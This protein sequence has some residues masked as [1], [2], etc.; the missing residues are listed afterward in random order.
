MRFPSPLLLGGKPQG[1][2]PCRFSPKPPLL[3]PRKFLFLCGDN[4]RENTVVSQLGICSLNGK[5]FLNVRTTFAKCEHFSQVCDSVNYPFV[6]LLA[7][8][9]V[10]QASRVKIRPKAE[11]L[12]LRLGKLFVKQS[13]Q[14]LVRYLCNSEIYG[15]LNMKDNNCNK[16]AKDCHKWTNFRSSGSVSDYMSLSNCRRENGCEHD[17]RMTS[18]PIYGTNT[19]GTVTE[20]SAF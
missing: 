17:Y 3:T 16:S 7:E 20:P 6:E 9:G 10:L 18:A 5:I 11:F 19:S 12:D 13:V 15:D 1:L 2:A 4:L 14:L 8:G